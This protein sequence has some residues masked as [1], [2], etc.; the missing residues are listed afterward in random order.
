MPAVLLLASYHHGDPWSQGEIN[1]FMEGL[2]PVGARVFVE[3]LDA[4]RFSETA[5]QSQF[6]AYLGTKYRNVPLA[7]LV[8]CDDAALDFWLRLRPTL[9]PGLPLVFCGINDFTPARIA[10]YDNITGVGESPDVVGT[11]ELALALVPGARTVLAFGS[12]TTVSARA[13]ME[14]FRR[15]AAALE[16]RVRPVEILNASLESAA[17]ALASA[18]T[19]AVAMR[20][21]SLPS[22]EAENTVQPGQDTSELA[23]VSAVPMFGLWDFDLGNGTLGGRV[24]RAAAQGRAAASIVG[25]ILAGRPA[26]DIPV[27]DIPAEMVVDYTEMQRFGLSMDR[28]PAKATLINEPAT[29]FEQHKGLLWAGAAALAVFVPGGCILGWLL[30]ARRRT[31]ARLLESERRYRELVESANSLIL[32]FDATGRLLFVNE[33]AERLLGYTRSELLAG[34]AV[35]WPAAPPDL[36]SLLA[37]AMAAPQSLARGDSENEI[38][39][40]DGHRVYLHWDNQPLFDATGKPEGWLA[41][42]SDITARRLAEEALAARAMAEEELSIFG[43]ELLADAPDAVDRALTRLLTAFSLGRAV[44]F[45]NVEDETH[46][47]GCRL[48]GEACAAGLTLQRGHPDVAFI[49]YS[50]DGFQWADRLAAGECIAGPVDDFPE[51]VQ[52]IMRA[53]DLTSVL[54]APVTCRNVWAGAIVV[55]DVR[56]RRTFTRQEQSLLSTA[57]SLLSAHLSRG[58]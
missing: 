48:A 4:R 50:L 31:E 32:R 53:F 29:V 20:L 6:A 11:M 35:F 23:R 3:H 12:D 56:T 52:N 36:S 33:Y 28:V 49:P 45:E 13:N 10:G 17:A 57:A 22:G 46:G 39:T 47:L 43:R 16:R 7:V 2:A 27:V 30:A 55:G 41:V 54:A 51:T 1:G 18:P 19:D 26:G 8:A 44:W 40:K 38:T 21:T 58:R 5:D 34:K 42:G 37:R 24:L 15:A 9:F 25:Q 14:R